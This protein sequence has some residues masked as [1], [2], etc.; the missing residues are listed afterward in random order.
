MSGAWYGVSVS[1]RSGRVTLC[2]NSFMPVRVSVT[3]KLSEEDPKAVVEVKLKKWGLHDRANRRLQ[4][5]WREEVTIVAMQG[6]LRKS[7]GSC[8]TSCTSSPTAKST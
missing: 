3:P 8:G 1:R 7:S 4:H 2:T 6:P 5:C